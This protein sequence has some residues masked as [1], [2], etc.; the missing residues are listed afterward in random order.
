MDRDSNALNWFLG[1]D[2]RLK[3]RERALAA[4][5]I[6]GRPFDKLRARSGPQDDSFLRTSM[7]HEKIEDGS[8]HHK[9]TF[10][11]IVG[12]NRTTQT[13]AALNGIQLLAVLNES[14][15]VLQSKVQELKPEVGAFYISNHSFDVYRIGIWTKTVLDIDLSFWRKGYFAH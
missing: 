13:R 14:Q 15:P 7:P 10:R 11:M 9:P 1:E 2:P 6:A 8:V 4:Q 12:G 5:T 3:S